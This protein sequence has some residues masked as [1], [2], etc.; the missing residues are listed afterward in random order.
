MDPTGTLMTLFGK[1]VPTDLRQLLDPARSAMLI[2]DMQNYACS[3][4]GLFGN[5]DRRLATYRN[6]IP[7]ISRLADLCRN[8]GLVVVNVRM[9]TLPDGKSSSPAWMRFKMRANPVYRTEDEAVWNAAV[10]GTWQ[11]EFVDELKPRPGDFVVGKFRS[12]ALHGTDL[13][14][15]LRSNKI[16]SVLVTGEA[17][18][19]CVES[20]VR[21]LGFHDYFPIL[22]SDCVGSDEPELHDASMRVMSAYRADVARSDEIMEILRERAEAIEV[23]E[24]PL[25][26]HR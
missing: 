12:S 5:D 11:A 17:T 16:E 1:T 24:T 21:D 6:I 7:R 8:M 9:R 18:E 2:I 15:I 25:S 14:L 13:D 3:P 10:D 4:G 20:T 19:G 26:V 22:V 23:G